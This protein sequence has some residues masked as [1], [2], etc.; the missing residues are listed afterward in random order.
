MSLR[1]DLNGNGTGFAQMLNAAKT[2]ATAFSKSVE[3]EVGSSWGGIGKQFAASV[4]GIFSFEGVKSGFEWFVETGKQIK[5]TAEQVDM[6]T[7]SWQKWTEAVERAGLS[8]EGFMRVIETLRQKRTDALTDPKARGELTKLGFTDADITGDMDM[9]EFTKR[10]LGNAN[11]GDLQRGYL[12]D[13][14]G[15]RG[16]KYASALGNFDTAQAPFS[17]QDLVEADEAAQSMKDLARAASMAT[18]ALIGNLTGNKRE[19]SRTGAWWS[20][21]MSEPFGK[22]FWDRVNSKANLA[23][24]KGGYFDDN[25]KPVKAAWHQNAKG[26]NTTTE[27]KK[28]PMDAKLAEQADEMAIHEQEQKQ[29]LLDSQRGLMTIGQRH[30]SIM[31]EMTGLQSQIALRT[32][33][34]TGEG[35]L[36]DAQREELSGVTGKART[37]AVTA[38]REK[39]KDQTEEMQLRYNKDKTDLREKPLDYSVD[40]MSKVGLYSASNVAF[41]PLLNVQQKANQIL[42]EIRNGV[43][44]LNP[45]RLHNPHSP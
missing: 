21:F 3:H 41:N 26:S 10:A 25:Y 17:K 19:T 12:A 2:Q 38:L 31:Q 9:S 1:V 5:E 32:K 28:D 34:A 37:F 30:Q 20:A 15:N 8:S 23:A 42:T 27:T 36:T 24:D 33:L 4:A 40:S 16:L 29:R 43:R 11:G 39:Y 13:I 7:D 44:D 45:S 35:F 6:S 18:I 14:I 22:N